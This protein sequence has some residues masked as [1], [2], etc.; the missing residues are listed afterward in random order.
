MKRILVKSIVIALCIVVVSTIVFVA[1]DYLFPEDKGSETNLG[2]RIFFMGCCLSIIGFWRKM[3][4]T[5][6]SK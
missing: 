2:W 3:R 1:V 4:K 6:L 5:R